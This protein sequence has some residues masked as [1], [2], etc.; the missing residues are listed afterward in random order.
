MHKLNLKSLKLTVS[1]LNYFKNLKWKRIVIKGEKP[2]G[3]RVKFWLNFKKKIINL[4]IINYPDGL[5]N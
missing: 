4:K 3:H 1:I 2:A 5:H